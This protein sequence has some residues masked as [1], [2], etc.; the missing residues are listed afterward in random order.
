MEKVSDTYKKLGI[1]FSFPIIIKDANGNETYFEN[2]K[3]YWH[4]R[5]FSDKG[6]VTYYEDSDGYKGGTPRGQ[7]CAGKVIEVDGNGTLI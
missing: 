5:E 4:K 6:K 2:S 1:D 3:D 7:S